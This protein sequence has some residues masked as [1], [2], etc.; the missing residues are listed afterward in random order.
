SWLVPKKTIPEMQEGVR[1]VLAKG[2]FGLLAGTVG[3]IIFLLATGRMTGTTASLVLSPVVT[4]TGT[5]L[6]FYFGAGH[7]SPPNGSS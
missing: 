7:H 1:G 6:G 3:A 5:A 2:L 4:L